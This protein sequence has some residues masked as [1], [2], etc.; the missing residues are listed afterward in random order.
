MCHSGWFNKKLNG[1]Q[2][3]RIFRNTGHWEEEGVWSPQPGGE[4]AAGAVQ[5][6]SYKATRQK[7][8]W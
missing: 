5:G 4:E 8:D 1:Q 7:V 6:K 2:L 3:G